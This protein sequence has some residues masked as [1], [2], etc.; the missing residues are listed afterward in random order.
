MTATQSWELVKA[1][2]SDWLE[3]KAPRLGA[4]L[5]YY[6]IFSLA[7]LLV[8]A[9][10]IA[11]AVLGEK[12]VQGQLSEQLQ[13]TI[14]PGPASVIQSMIAATRKSGG[15]TLATVISVG[16]LLFGA[17][18]VFAQLKDALNTVWEVPP[19]QGGGVKGFIRDRFLSFAMVMGIGFLL[20]VSLVISSILTAITRQASNVL[21][22]PDFVVH[23]G[24]VVISLVVITLLFA[25]MFKLLPDAKVAWSDVWVGAIVTAVLF[26]I[27]KYAISVY[28]AH[29]AVSS[30][31]GAAGSVVALLLWIY[32]ASL[33]LLL[34]AEF[35]QAYA[36]RFGSRF[37][38][39]SQA[40]SLPFAMP[41]LLSDAG[42]RSAFTQQNE[43]DDMASSRMTQTESEYLQEQLE[44]AQCAMRRTRTELTSAVRTAASPAE[45]A[46]TY[47]WAAVGTA[48]LAGTAVGMFLLHRAQKRPRTRT[49]RL[50][51]AIRGHE[52]EPRVRERPHEVETRRNGGGILNSLIAAGSGA[53]GSMLKTALHGAIMTA[54]S[55]KT[56]T[57]AARSEAQEGQPDWEPGRE[58]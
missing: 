43:G 4:A 28:M 41:A 47:P 31:Y 49:E 36:A 56:A 37:Q 25:M 39:Q 3:D 35:T 1:S 40:A 26:T 6:T 12:A 15:G 48:M 20:L 45:W 7:P 55:A 24:D 53:L 38:A 30:A 51:D 14:G 42:E 52:R 11:G 27:G 46:R 10:A 21:P 19:R 17:T 18:G 9:I 57:A 54:V 22:V 34:G 16:V 5:A 8:V 44:A 50:I 58:F 33:I 13:G 29:S 23:I 32:Y 2:V